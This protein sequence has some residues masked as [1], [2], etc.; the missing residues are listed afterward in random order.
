MSEYGIFVIFAGVLMCSA[1]VGMVVVPGIVG[2]IMQIS[3][4]RLFILAHLI[5]VFIMCAI[6]I[7]VNVIVACKRKGKYTVI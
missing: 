2:W 4:A 3:D 5:C 7:G 6:F 1:S